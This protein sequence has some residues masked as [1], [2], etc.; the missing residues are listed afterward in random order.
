VS[1]IGMSH[2]PIVTLKDKVYFETYYNHR[3]SNVQIDEHLQRWK[4]KNYILFVEH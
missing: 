4:Y 2:E 3:L 1:T